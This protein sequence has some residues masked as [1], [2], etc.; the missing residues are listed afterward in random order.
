MN[1]IWIG[2]GVA[3]LFLLWLFLLRTWL[4]L[5]ALAVIVGGGWIWWEIYALK[6]AMRT[7][8]DR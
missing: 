7:P 5:I 1:R 8:P 6:K 3:A 4:I 2:F